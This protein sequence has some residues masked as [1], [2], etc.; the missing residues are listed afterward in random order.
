MYLNPRRACTVKLRVLASLA[1]MARFKTSAPRP[2][3]QGIFQGSSL[4][5]I[6]FCAFANDL[7]LLHVSDAL[8]VQYA[9]D[10]QVMISESKSCLPA[11]IVR[12]E[13]ALA[14][15]GD[16]ILC[17][18][19]KVNVTKFELLTI[20][21]RQ[22]LRS[23]PRFTILFRDTTLSPR[24][25][26]RNQGVIFDQHLNWDA[27]VSALSRKCCGILSH[28]PPPTV[29]P[30][31]ATTSLQIS[32]PKSSPPLW[33]LTSVTVCS[34]TATA[35]PETSAAFRSSSTSLLE[36]CKHDHVSDVRDA[37]GWFDALVLFLY[38]TLCL[39]HRVPPH[40]RAGESCRSIHHQL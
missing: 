10:T 35:P 12:M 25:E 28:T 34:Y 14:S 17:N 2:I 38:Q 29:S 33:S 27:H 40:R 16:Y 18:G 26:A 5:P 21:S 19:L 11:F 39:L 13:S 30:T 31:Y 8:V 3:Q 32:F 6:L 36:S 24:P 22:N 15:L 37:L 20:G 23:L 1:L 7:T 9:D 4:G